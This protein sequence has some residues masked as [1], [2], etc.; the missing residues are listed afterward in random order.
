MPAN[1]TQP[2]Q[3]PHRVVYQRASKPLIEMGI[4]QDIFQDG[5]M[6]FIQGKDETY[7]FTHQ[8]KNA[9]GEMQAK[10]NFKR[11]GN[12]VFLS[13]V[14]AKSSSCEARFPVGQRYPH[15]NK[16]NRLVNRR[17]D[18]PVSVKIPDYINSAGDQ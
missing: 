18:Q 3:A 1:D 11:Q 8:V 9:D 7:A 15:I 14:F 2:R 13:S 10:A 12:K 17:H 6:K 4:P 5:L 16:M